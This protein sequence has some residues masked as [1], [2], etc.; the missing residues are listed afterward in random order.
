MDTINLWINNVLLNWHSR[1]GF[2]KMLSLC[3][4]LVVMVLGGYYFLFEQDQVS[5]IATVGWLVYGIIAVAIAITIHFYSQYQRFDL[6]WNYVFTVFVDTLNILVF[7]FLSHNPYSELF[8]LLLLPLI[9]TAYFF[10]RKSAVFVSFLVMF[11]Y[12]VVYSVIVLNIEPNLQ[13][14]VFFL[15]FV[16]RAMFLLGA[17]WIYR[18]QNNFPHQD[19]RRG[20]SPFKLKNQIKDLLRDLKKFVEYDTTS[21]MLMYRGHLQIIACVGF[22]EKEDDIYQIEFPVNDLRYP[23]ANVIK[24]KLARIE[25]PE[26][27]PSFKQARYCAS[28]VRSWLGVPLLSPVTGECFGMISI[29]SRRVNAFKAGDA[30]KAGWFAA[31]VSSMLMEAQL[32]PA[33]MTQLTKRENLLVLLEKWALLLSHNSINWEDDIQAARALVKLGKDLFRVEDCS[34]FFMRQTVDKYNNKERVLHLI[35][36]S[37]IPES[38]FNRHEIKVTGKP[39]DGLTG[40][41][42]KNNRIINLSANDISS[43]PYRTGFTDHLQY[44]FSKQSRQV[45][46]APFRDSRNTPQGAIK[47]E[48]R[49][50][51]SSESQFTPIEEHIFSVFVAMAGLI[52]ENI[53]Q[54]QFNKRRMDN[55][56]NLRGIMHPAGIK[57][58]DDILAN[59]PAEEIISIRKSSLFQIRDMIEYSK[60]VLD[61]ELA[62]S[63]GK[64]SLENEGLAPAIQSYIEQLGGTLPGF[65]PICD[66]IR[67]ECDGT[68]DELPHRVRIAFFN[69]ARESIVN[70]VRHS[71]I[72]QQENGYAV[73]KFYR[74][75]NDSYHLEIEDNGAG[76]DLSTVNTDRRSFGLNDM[77]FQKETI[78]QIGHEAILKIDTR[79]NYGTRIHLSARIIGE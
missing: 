55:I 36:S 65:K 51:Q 42:V 48:N 1:Q 33:A 63:T 39:G 3:R 79:Q 9:T 76:F 67:L 72:E 40:R 53:R 38:F 29:D 30:R 41:A 16:V 47:L 28:H 70:V 49:M 58:I 57:P 2:M 10:T 50:G 8:L 27:F 43:S 35:A 22:D 77:Q 26:K 75:N 66:T 19:E 7:I 24:T 18:I 25:D 61:G 34:I 37:D 15:I 31:Q 62:I 74:E 46:I 69:V 23:N 73:I 12:F 20:T 17:T 78:R 14:F 54:K 13:F 56:H 60:S 71:K 64:F 21:V 11:F 68:R 59:A 44:L 32:G 45:I 4:V 52:I 6:L 5:W